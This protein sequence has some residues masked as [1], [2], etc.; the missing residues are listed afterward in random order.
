MRLFSRRFAFTLLCGL[1]LLG[2]CSGDNNDAKAIV[3][4]NPSPQ[5]TS[6]KSL[7]SLIL[8]GAECA[9]GGIQVDSGIDENGNGVLDVAEIDTS[10]I[11]CNGT[12]GTDGLTAL[13][14]QTVVLAGGACATGG[15]RFDVGMDT[16]GNGILD[17]PEVNSSKFLCNGSAGTGG[18]TGVDTESPV[19]VSVISI[20]NTEVLVQFS[21]PMIQIDAENPV[22]YSITTQALET[23]LPVWD[24]VFANA[25]NS[26]V[27]LSTFS[28]SSLGYSIT[29]SNLR[30]LAGN[31][32]ADPTRLVDPSTALFVGTDPTGSA[33]ADS[34][35]D[36]LPDHTE[37]VGWDVTIT[38][39]NGT[40]S[41]WHVSSDPGD[42]NQVV[43]AA[44]NVAAKDTD[45]DGVTDNEERH[46]GMDPRQPDTDGDTLTDNQ[47]WNTIYSDP[48]HQD[49][50]GDGTQDGFEFYSY[51]TSPVLADTD[52]DQINDTN[53]VLGRNRDP[54]IADLPLYGINI[55]DVRLQIDE[56]FTFVDVLGETVTTTSSSDVT[57]TNG[58]TKSRGSSDTLTL[59][60]MINLL[61]GADLKFV[62]PSFIPT[63]VL[64]KGQVNIGGTV[65]QVR[66]ITRD[67]VIQAQQVHQ[68][69]L[70]KANELNTTSTVTRE[71]VGARI[72]ADVTIENRG[73]LAFAISNL[74][75]TVLQRSRESSRRF[76]P[77]ATLIANSALVTGQSTTFNLGP[78]T[79]D[80]GPI[81][82][83]S[84]DVFPNLVD[85]LM[86]AAPGALIF[87]VSNFDITD[88][89]GRVFSFAN[90]VA[91]DRT[92]AIFIDFGD[93]EIQ[94]HL[95]ATALQPDVDGIVGPPGGFVG[96]FN[97]DGS[98]VGIPL[99]FALQDI[100]ELTKNATVKDGIVAGLD[101]IADSTAAGDDVQLIPPLTT[102]LGIG[103]IVVSAGQNGILDTIP[104]ADDQLEITTGYETSLTCSVDSGQ[105]ARRACSV[106]LDCN[107]GGT[108]TCSGPRTLVRFGNQRTGDFNRMW[109]VLTSGQVPAGGNIDQLVLKPG[110]DIYFAFVQ[111]LDRD[112][113]FAREEFLSGST[114]S[115]VDDLANSS[116]GI[117]DAIM[118]LTEFGMETT[119]YELRTP[120]FIAGG[121]GIPDSTDTDR[122]GL[123]DFAEVRIGW[124][125]SAD[126]GI[127][128][129]VFPSPRLVD[130]DG[131]KLLD[132]QE[133]DL[134]RFCGD[135]NGIPDTRT[136]ALCAF[137]N[138]PV[139][140]QLNA[141]AIIAGSN[142]FADT[143][144]QGDDEQ[145]I[146]SSTIR[147]SFNTPVI[148]PGPNGIIDT[149]L[150]NSQFN[151]D[152]YA[153]L[154][155]LARIPPSTSP[156]VA[157]TDADGLDDFREL[158]P[159]F[160]GTSVR[161]GIQGVL[162][163][164]V[165]AGANGFAE[166]L[167]N[168]I[169][170]DIQEIPFGTGGLPFD[171]VV[172]SA[173][174]NGIIDSTFLPG[175][176][177]QLQTR[178]IP[179]NGLA[180]TQAIGDD[181]QQA[182]LG[183]PVI[184]SGIV[185]LPGANGK[186]DSCG[187]VLDPLNDD[188][189]P[190]G[191]AGGDDSYTLGVQVVTDPL[192]RDTDSDLVADGIELAKGGNPTDPNDGDDFRDSDQDGLSDN[193]EAEL[194]W[195]VSSN[196][197]LTPQ[198]VLSNPSRP[199]S[200][201][202][203]LPDFAERVL[204]TDPNNA[205][206]DGDGLSDYDEFANF[207][208][209]FGL[210]VR[211]PGFVIDGAGSQQY[212][213]DPLQMDSDGDTLSDYQ[214]LVEGYQVLF[215]GEATPRTIFTNPQAV[216]TDLDGR[217]DAE[218]RVEQYIG[219]GGD[220][221]ANTQAN[222]LSDD[223][224]VIPFLTFDLTNA[225]SVVVSAGPNGILE[226]NVQAGDQLFGTGQ[227]TDATDP[228]TDGD[229]RPDGV[230]ITAGTNPRVPD[231]GIT[232]TFG[233]LYINHIN[234]G[235]IT[236]GAS[237]GLIW[238]LT[239]KTPQDT[240]IG[241]GTL[242]SSVLNYDNTISLP[243]TSNG[244]C[245][246]LMAGVTTGELLLRLNE[247]TPF[248]LQEGESFTVKGIIYEFDF[249]SPDCGLEP[250][251]IPTF[252]GSGCVTRFNETYSFNDFTNG[253][254]VLFPTPDAVN[255]VDGCDWSLEV[256]VQAN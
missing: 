218:E 123:G 96:G 233:D 84:R 50:D 169:T 192:R 190:C 253:G 170:D 132:K 130:S 251:Y 30:D 246:A 249:N 241:N 97:S 211:F 187:F 206:T 27:L 61:G 231:V 158:H 153:S 85:E 76:F 7:A 223:V 172:G 99:D 39:G 143:G 122:D 250:Y 201:F 128:Q 235:A 23:H 125:V 167:V 168:S 230:E 63:E 36:T 161:D 194:G 204:R 8:P 245:P 105:N 155:S 176:D 35:G 238:L 121:D 68:D 17:A 139:V 73:D 92:A 154:E 152:E 74:E 232:V 203:G 242:V 51:R 64:V 197:A 171:T 181:I 108:G 178:S 255:T 149:V 222:P 216:D 5:D 88:E 20:S 55:G 62:P 145:L 89:Y 148:G 103:S 124:Q 196:G 86:Q 133:Q 43:T 202:D 1:I 25:D 11:I 109:V 256:D 111:D 75:I 46:G 160:V 226:T 91:R 6:S 221:F 173:G 94:R 243:I 52:G 236:G 90:Q 244:S 83:S 34:D 18:G 144:V 184:S 157:D 163:E 225:E 42:P 54:R 114:D 254:Q 26:T 217:T 185:I 87:E 19:V 227:I 47:E 147:V 116:F 142:N 49:T 95:V 37:L 210:D 28:Q 207:E 156:V 159:F 80:R 82:F 3:P 252:V 106:D 15:L 98:P 67:S 214:E 212:G 179:G 117:E 33:V 189:A 112:G 165:V 215:A 234:D 45:G 44:V 229:G 104:T 4:T 174:P 129:R 140:A 209:F 240:A 100:L 101:G 224:Q 77:V 199:D 40:T 14:E 78:F 193:E 113:L 119:G 58:E 32:V 21:E 237:R 69:S 66:G 38:N 79:S 127:L 120:V 13:V 219:V 31:P 29:V 162:E 200:D 248:T 16:N 110:E 183:G 41:T 118:G 213:S 70:N 164:I 93:G 186:I 220:L 72:D 175:V 53:E 150:V 239:V 2:G 12:N 22:S 24:A 59:E 146:T 136:D 102:G 205:D 177:D 9:T 198:L 151:D 107:S 135:V 228:D 10:E 208:Q 134:R 247:S 195:L 115:N 57:L 60:A 182:F 191:I 131:D 188:G 137:K 71:I 141:I 166:F 65:S 126:G 81:L 138:D 48:T 56:R 180:E